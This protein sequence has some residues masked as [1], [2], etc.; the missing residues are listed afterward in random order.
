MYAFLIEAKPK[1][2]GAYDFFTFTGKDPVPVV[3]RGQEYTV[4]KGTR[5]GVR[6]SSNRKFI[7]MIFPE[8]KNRVF[9]LDQETAKRLAKGVTR[10][11]MQ[12]AH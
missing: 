7:R 2:E 11:S 12:P 5:F 8:N 4:E 1:D 3:F 6:P 10:R 9:T